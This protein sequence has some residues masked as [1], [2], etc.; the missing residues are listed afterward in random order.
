MEISILCVELNYKK[1][2]NREKTIQTFTPNN[3]QTLA[4]GLK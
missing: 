3:E 4:F 1:T 2:E